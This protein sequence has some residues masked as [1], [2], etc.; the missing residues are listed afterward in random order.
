A[1]AGGVN[2]TMHPKKYIGLSA[3]QV[4]GSHAGSRSF[5]DGDGHLTAEGV[6][7]VLL[8]TLASAESDGHPLLALIKS[9]AV[10]HGGH[11]LGFSV[12]SAK[13]QAALIDSNFKR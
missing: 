4:L 10:N 1:I 12:P 6:G 3:G 9:T 11:T 13:L 5:S 7:A 2:L 8:K